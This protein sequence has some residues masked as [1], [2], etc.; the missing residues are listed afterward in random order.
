MEYKDYYKILGV[1]KDA[2]EKAI[3]RAY[4][5]LARQYHPDKNPEN[6]AA[7]EKFKEINEAY[8]VLG[9]SENRAKYDQLGSNYHRFRQ[10]GGNPGD[11]DF[12][13]WFNQAGQG[14]G[15]QQANINFGDMF[16]GG[17]GGFSDF[18]ST[19]F[20]NTGGRAG[21]SQ[22]D[23]FRRSSTNPSGIN[24][25][26]NQTVEISLEEAYSGTTRRF[27]RNGTEFTATIPAG[28]KNGTKVRLRG[29]GNEG[30]YG[31]GDLFLVI[32]VQPHHLFKHAG[33]NLQV[34]VKVDVV[35][36]VLGGKV[37]VPTL[38]GSVSLSISAGTQGG[39]TIRLRGKGMPNLRDVTKF[40]DL[41]A[42]IRIQTPTQLTEDERRLYE[43][44]AELPQIYA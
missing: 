30:A 3:K 44:L 16:G 35:T 33:N 8:E 32:E 40:G 4:R 14:G 7:E 17:N 24:L 36:A 18:F 9:T 39:Q 28:A 34:D 41:M 11:F 37:K 22:Q 13:Q 42:Q 43:Q 38:D 19:I 31:T 6:D 5:Q 1:A 15:F 20:G 12:S 29:K 10:T 27:R 25:D 2:D 23:M 26:T 21:Q